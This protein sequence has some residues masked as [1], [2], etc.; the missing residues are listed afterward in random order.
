MLFSYSARDEHGKLVAGKIKAPS[1]ETAVSLLQGRGYVVLSLEEVERKSFFERIFEFLESVKKKDL[2]VFWRQFGVLL[3]SGVPID[4]SLKS[5]YRQTKNPILKEVLY[6]IISDVE[7]GSSLSTAFGKHPHIFSDFFINLLRAAE[8]SGKVEDTVNYIASYLEKEVAFSKKIFNALI[9]PATVI[10]LFL[11]VIIVMVLFVFPQLS[12]FFITSQIK[13][14]WITQFF[15]KT[16]EFLLEWGLGVLLIL[17]FGLFF[18]LNYI[19]TEE[20]KAIWSEI[21]L[22]LPIFG[23]IF[24]RSALLKFCQGVAV[25]IKGG[26]SL[27]TAIE[28]GGKI[29]SNVIYQEIASEIAEGVRRGESFS[30]LVASYPEYF[31]EITATMIAIGEQTGRL[32]SLLEKLAKFYEEEID[33]VLSTLSELIQPIIIVILGVFVGILIVSILWPIYNLVQS[34]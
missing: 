8:I 33:A 10:L 6:E 30:A 21:Q 9:Y 24:R 28:M 1:K 13:L 18:L 12:E 31:E 32:D 7:G 14:P 3:A 23:K 34:L 4:R 25:L 5:L 29:T 15:L 26:I 2:L 11:A 22:K 16:G 20:G 19:R 17:I 27:P